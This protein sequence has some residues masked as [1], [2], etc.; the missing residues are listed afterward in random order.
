MKRFL[1]IILAALM[2]ISL[3]AC[4]QKEEPKQLGGWTLT[5]G[6]GCS[7][8]SLEAFSK[9]MEGLAGVNYTP[10]ALL[11]TQLVSGT[12]Y[13]LLCEAAVVYPGALPYYSLVY[14]Y[15]DLQGGAKITN[16]VAL[17]LGRIA[18]SGVIEDCQPEGGQLLGGW[19]VDRES[20]VEVEDAVLHLGSQIVSGTNHCVLCTG[21]NLVFAY[22]NLDG[23]LS[24]TRTVSLDIA[25]LSQPSEG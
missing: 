18:E 10:L 1:A 16:I 21:W 17:D 4:G 22:E 13:C 7:Q 11:G 25:A 19:Q 23:E 15:A 24:I 2:L 5:A 6:D 3:A 20:G 12:N 9:A 14:V 8:D